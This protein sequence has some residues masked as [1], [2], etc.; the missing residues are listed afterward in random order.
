MGKCLYFF[1]RY[2][3]KYLKVKVLSV[4]IFKYF[5]NYENEMKQNHKNVYYCEIQVK[6]RWLLY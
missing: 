3:L 6:S 5:K 1:E 2:M 4:F